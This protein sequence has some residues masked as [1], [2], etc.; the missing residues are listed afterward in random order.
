MAEVVIAPTFEGWRIAARRL[1]ADGVAPSD[2]VW[3]ERPADP[4]GGLFDAAAPPEA[5]ETSARDAGAGPGGAGAAELKVP[6]A[7]VAL[8]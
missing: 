7:F 6:R 2:V 5:P 1:I 8:A 4:R 3:R